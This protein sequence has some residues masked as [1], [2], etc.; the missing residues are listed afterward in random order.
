MLARAELPGTFSVYVS[1]SVNR[2]DAS[3]SASWN[4][5]IEDQLFTSFKLANFRRLKPTK[6][7]C[8]KK[9]TLLHTT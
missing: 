7:C 9:S 8:H 6:R 4:Q 5:T 3:A 2:G 1:Y